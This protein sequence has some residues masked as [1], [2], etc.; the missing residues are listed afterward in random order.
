MSAADPADQSAPWRE[1]GSW[2]LA[3]LGPGFRLQ[4]RIS[5][6]THSARLDGFMSPALPL[7]VLLVGVQAGAV[8]AETSVSDTGRFELT[9]PRS[10][11]V[12]LMFLGADER[13][14][15]SPPFWI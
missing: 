6:R 10:G 7:T 14:L 9:A 5:R 3:Y 1:V 8:T 12:R 4:L 11:A 13:P 15:L 2:S